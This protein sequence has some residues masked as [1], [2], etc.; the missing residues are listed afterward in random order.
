MKVGK[1]VATVVSTIQVDVFRGRRLLVCDL[2]ELDGTATGRSLIAVDTVGAGDCFA[3][4]LSVALAEGKSLVEAAR[5]AVCAAALATQV[6]GAQ[7]S[8]PRRN[9]IET[10]LAETFGDA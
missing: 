3:A 2:V 5:F 4:T 1:V 8:L 9:E 10:R 7:P 6:E